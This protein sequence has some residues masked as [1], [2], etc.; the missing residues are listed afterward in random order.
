MNKGEKALA[1]EVIIPILEYILAEIA[2]DDH[3]YTTYIEF[4]LPE[5]A[6]ELAVFK[7]WCKQKIKELE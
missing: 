6:D 5:H 4:S 3:T 2:D 7:K 1:K